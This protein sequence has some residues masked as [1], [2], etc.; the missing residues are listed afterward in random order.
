MIKQ[1][2]AIN[3]PIA[4]AYTDYIEH[5]DRR[6]SLALVALNK[7]NIAL[8]AI[9]NSS[10]EMYC[11]ACFCVPGSPDARKYLEISLKAAVAYFRLAT[12]EGLKLTFQIDDHQIELE[13]A[14]QKEGLKLFE[15]WDKSI[16]NA[17]LL[18]DKEALL[19]LLRVD[20]RAHFREKSYGDGDNADMARAFVYKA[21]FSRRRYLGSLFSLAEAK[22]GREGG[23]AIEKRLY[24]QVKLLKALVSGADEF[25][26]NQ[27]MEQALLTHQQY[28]TESDPSHWPG[29]TAF[30][31]AAIAALAYDNWG[32]KVTVENEYIPQWIV[33]DAG[34]RAPWKIDEKSLDYPPSAS[35]ELNSEADQLAFL[36]DNG[37]DAQLEHIDYYID[38]LFCG[39]DPM[40]FMENVYPHIWYIFLNK[41]DY[42]LGGDETEIKA[43]IQGNIAVIAKELNELKK[44]VD[45]VKL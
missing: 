29:V 5:H 26:Y 45:Q 6:L 9:Q 4:D 2:Y 41:M 20:P 11:V 3:R 37:L 12:E 17:T 27:I 25:E 24:S 15:R 40:D 7:K 44:I 16:Q 8:N 32:Y 22:L 39:D 19:S 18:R 13:S 35:L 1:H 14:Y 36:K 28:Y 42:Q 21:L 38:H 34:G 43:Y 33:E 23:C 10:F 31:Q 30:P